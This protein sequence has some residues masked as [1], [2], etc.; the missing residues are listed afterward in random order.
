MLLAAVR[1][2]VGQSVGANP[3]APN[4]PPPWKGGASATAQAT[5]L[6]ES[7]FTYEEDAHPEL[8]FTPYLWA[9]AAATTS[10]VPWQAGCSSGGLQLFPPSVSS[11]GVGIGPCA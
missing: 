8:F 5:A 6:L 9:L 11:P 10:D 1:P 7:K 2:G 3:S 4:V